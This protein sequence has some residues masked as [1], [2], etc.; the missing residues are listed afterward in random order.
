MIPHWL[1]WAGVV[2]VLL[3]VFIRH[4]AIYRY[5]GRCQHLSAE[6]GWSDWSYLTDSDGKPVKVRY[7][8]KHCVLCGHKWVLYADP[9]PASS[10]ETGRAST[11][12]MRCVS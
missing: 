8:Q 9:R 3:V 11:R 4:L 7:R 10:E 12:S 2:F 6:P 5:C 1:Y